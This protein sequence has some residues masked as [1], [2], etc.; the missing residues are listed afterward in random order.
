[1]EEKGTKKGAADDKELEK[2][3]KQLWKDIR[4]AEERSGLNEAH[5]GKETLE[6]IHRDI[7][8]NVNAMAELFL[9]AKR[10][11]DKMKHEKTRSAISVMRHER[12]GR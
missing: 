10:L 5:F 4:R 1:M 8:P 3:K 6:K 9:E 7:T 2:M 11:Q 12:T